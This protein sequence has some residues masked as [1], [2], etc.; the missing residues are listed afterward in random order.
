MEIAG[1][2]NYLIYPD[3]KVQNKKTKRYLKPSTDKNGYKHVILCK[4]G[5]M[6]SYSVH[7]LVA[8]HYIPNPE[9]KR[10]VDHIYR[11]KSDNRVENLRWVSK[12]ENEQNKGTR[13]DNT[14]GHKN[15][16]YHKGNNKWEYQKVFRGVRIQK[17]FKTKTDA[18]CYKYIFTL[19]I[20]AGLV[21]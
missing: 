13:K 20:R 8:L 16:H 15:I 12:S 2:N 3:G 9:N 21:Q 7:R 17:D 19:K 10:E 5:T 14:S 6:K 4:N 1:Y 11:D 18:L